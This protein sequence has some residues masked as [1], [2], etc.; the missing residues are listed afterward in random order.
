[1]RCLPKA[2]AVRPQRQEARQ[3]RCAANRAKARPLAVA[4]RRR[5]A[6]ILGRA[7]LKTGV[8]LL[9]AS[10]LRAS[11]VSSSPR[12]D[13]SRRSIGRARLSHAPDRL[14][15]QQ[16]SRPDLDRVERSQLD[17]GVDR[18]P[19]NS[20]RLR[21]FVDRKDKGFHERLRVTIGGGRRLKLH[22]IA[23]G[24][25]GNPTPAQIRGRLQISLTARNANWHFSGSFR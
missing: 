4:C 12:A 17:K 14:G 3:E 24:S 1:M 13:P 8:D 22:M 11:A 20:E 16:G 18:R 23:H 19:A 6:L 7:H 5:C 2:R 10:A 25:C 15:R 21:G 9:S